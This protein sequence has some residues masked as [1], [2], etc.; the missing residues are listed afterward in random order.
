VSAAPASPADCAVSMTPAASTLAAGGRLMEGLF[1][2]GAYRL[3]L[4]AGQTWRDGESDCLEEPG[5]LG[6]DEDVGLVELRVVIICV[7]VVE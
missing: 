3:F 2:A 1:A 6:L 5:H 7:E 4:G